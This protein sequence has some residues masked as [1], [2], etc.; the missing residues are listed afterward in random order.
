MWRPA[1]IDGRWWV[2]RVVNRRSR[3]PLERS[4]MSFGSRKV[5]K[6]HAAE[7]NELDGVADGGES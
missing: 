7:W 5:A 1:L 3:V 6:R 4:P 2:V